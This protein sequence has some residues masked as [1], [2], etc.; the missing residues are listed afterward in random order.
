ME[1]KK[2]ITPLVEAAQAL[3]KII[4]PIT[5]IKMCTTVAGVAIIVNLD[6][7]ASLRKVLVTRVAHMQQVPV[8]RV[9]QL[10]PYNQI[11]FHHNTSVIQNPSKTRYNLNL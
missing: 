9:H 1:L 8:N 2:A 3:I 10:Q 4:T 11:S 6:M 5:E 7:A